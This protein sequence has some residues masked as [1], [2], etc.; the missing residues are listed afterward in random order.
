MK[1]IIALALLS[2][3]ALTAILGASAEGSEVSYGKTYSLVTPASAAYPDDGIKLTDGIFGTIPDGGTN[4]YSSGAYVGFNQVDVDS[5]G[6]FVVILDLGRVYSDLSA[7]TV[8]FLNETSAGI[9]APASVSFALADERNGAYTELGTL[10]TA[11][12]T[13]NGLAESFSATLA[14]EDVSGRYVKVTIEHLNEITDSEGNTKAAGW[15]FIDE[16]SV[17]SSGNSSGGTGEESGNGTNSEA[18]SESTPETTPE[19]TPESSE[20]VDESSE[21]ETP[22]P[23]DASAGIFAFVLLALSAFAMMG[24]LF[25]GRRKNNEF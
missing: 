5:N 4:Y 17:Y 12:P 8:G 1:K 15:T 11:K 18:V 16:I 25:A 22:Q 7:F 19:S 6:N 21:A 13:E 23:G 9:Y 24:A 14:A 10:D 20:I 2:V 3:F